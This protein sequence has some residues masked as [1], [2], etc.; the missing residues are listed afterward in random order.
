M[1]TPEDRNIALLKPLYDIWNGTKGA[2]FDHFLDIVAD[3]VRWQ[4]L[5]R[6]GAGMEFTRC[7]ATKDEVVAYFNGL[8]RDW[9]MLSYDVHEYIAQGDRVVALSRCAFRHRRTGRTVET[10]KADVVR[11]RDGKIV[12]FF[13]F[14]DTAAA[15]S[16]GRAVA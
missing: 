9:E 6:G 2:R 15:D 8:A 12:Q 16:A 11:I 1:T 5:P 10:D 4:S 3:D 14:F 7:C 13:E